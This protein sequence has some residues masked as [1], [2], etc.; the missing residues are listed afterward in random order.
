MSENTARRFHF[1]YEKLAPQFG[2]ETR[3]STREFD[4]ESSNGKLMIAVTDIFD[5]ERY[6]LVAEN[7]RLREAL[8]QYADERNWEY[9]HA[10]RKRLFIRM[11]QVAFIDEHGYEL[12]Q[13]E[14]K[15]KEEHEKPA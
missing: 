8:A 13:R 5:A 10:Q 9:G 3:T 6:A 4:P 15:R 7:Q 2:Y 12:A 11:G 1:L 14:L